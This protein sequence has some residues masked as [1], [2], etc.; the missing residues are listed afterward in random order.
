MQEE[1][2]SLDDEG[3][4]S[5]MVIADESEGDVTSAFAANTHLFGRP[6][7]QIS[8]PASATTAGNGLGVRRS[9]SSGNVLSPSKPSQNGSGRRG[10]LPAA[11][12][13]SALFGDLPRAPSFEPSK[14][15]PTPRARYS[16]VV[17]ER[18]VPL[19]SA[20]LDGEDTAKLRMEKARRG[21][22][23]F[24]SAS[25]ASAAAT[26]SVTTAS[27]FAV[28]HSP[29]LEQEQ[30]NAV[31]GDE[32]EQ[33]E[34]DMSIADTRRVSNVF[35]VAFSSAHEDEADNV[36]ADETISQNQEQAASAT[37]QAGLYPSLAGLGVDLPT[38]AS[39]NEGQSALAF[40]DSDEEDEDNWLAGRED[41]QQ[42]Q[43]EEQRR[44]SM[45]PGGPVFAG[46]SSFPVASDAVTQSSQADD[47]EETHSE[48]P[49][50]H[51]GHS[52][53]VPLDD[54]YQ[55]QEE[56]LELEQPLEE[57]QEETGD[58]VEEQ[59]YK[60][61]PAPVFVPRTSRLSTVQERPLEEEEEEEDEEDDMDVT[62]VFGSYGRPSHQQQQQTAPPRRLSIA[63]PAAA[64]S[65]NKGSSPSKARRQSLVQ[66]GAGSSTTP[67][68]SPFRASAT[69][70]TLGSPAVAPDQAVAKSAPASGLTPNM[71]RLSDWTSTR[72]ASKPRASSVALPTSEAGDG[73][74]LASLSM[75]GVSEPAHTHAQGAQNQVQEPGISLEQFLNMADMQFMDGLLSVSQNAGAKARKSMAAPPPGGATDGA[76]VAKEV[77]LAEQVVAS[78]ATIPMME[79][80]QMV[81][82]GISRIES[83]LIARAFIADDA[84][85]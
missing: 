57:H 5:G 50:P 41:Q 37:S 18:E 52:A 28:H 30:Q 39:R 15:M 46:Q 25:T 44:E 63:H 4:P 65:P 14:S 31:D 23:A 84:R 16:T 17:G 13:A 20:G 71:R 78:G 61:L 3:E 72:S 36:E 43:D 79:S 38:K 82:D 21:S 70:A 59:Q 77:T 81:R 83:W 47:D 64:A 1:Q 48:E 22:L 62:G 33:S 76:H 10:S 29:S 54:E 66:V 53:N 73:F 55:Q 27:V 49:H 8:Q 19:G 85:A 9:S 68:K 6:A 58:A 2:D 26:T 7:S 24:Y 74:E 60:P 56:A 67:A 69:A 45:V 35:A 12:P 42:M 80:L 34:M 32:T 40:L 51:E 11:A 75:R